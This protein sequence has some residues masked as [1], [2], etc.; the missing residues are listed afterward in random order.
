MPETNVSQLAA[1]VGI[2]VERLLLQLSEAG[3]SAKSPDDTLSEQDKLRLLSYL[4][5]SHG[6]PDKPAPVTQD[7]SREKAHEVRGEEHEIPRTRRRRKPRPSGRVAPL[8]NPELPTRK[9]FVSYSW[10]HPDHISWVKKFAARLRTDGIEAIL[11]RWELHPGDPVTDFMERSIGESDFVLLI[12]TP[13]YRDR[14]NCRKGGVGFEGTIIT[15]EIY[16]KANHRKFIPILRQGSWANSSPTYAL[17]KLYID[18][19]E[20]ES[21]EEREEFGYRDLLLTILGRREAAPPL[22]RIPS[23]L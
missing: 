6:K 15:A 22:G 12:C 9:V 13:A 11:D 14:A 3:I 21:D 4:R 16:A 20:L 17:S 1:T 10:D 2:P 19:R 8:Q 18:M 23:N 7:N 5:R